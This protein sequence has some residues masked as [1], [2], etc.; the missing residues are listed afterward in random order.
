MKKRLERMR[1]N[2]DDARKEITRV[3]RCLKACPVD[4]V[5]AKMF[6]D[7]AMSKLAT[8]EFF[9]EQMKDKKLTTDEVE[10]VKAI[11]AEQAGLK[12]KAERLRE[13]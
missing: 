5:G 4:R 6:L 9:I 1:Q 2:I 12:L 3:E 7:A 10:T 11:A 8:V 13:K